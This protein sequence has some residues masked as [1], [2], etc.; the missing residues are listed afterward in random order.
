MADGTPSPPPPAGAGDPV[1]SSWRATRAGRA[2]LVVV[3]SLAVGLAFL[4]ALLP[5]LPTAPF[6][7]VAGACFARAWPRADAWLHEHSVFGPFRHMG[8]GEPSMTRRYKVIAIGI[9]CASFG[10]TLAFTPLPMAVRALLVL[11]CGVIVVFLARQP[12][13]VLKG[14]PPPGR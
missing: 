1:P 5:L 2:L 13:L 8:R 4:G 9:T 11:V 14:S 3:G 12:T 7:L 10:A 6:V